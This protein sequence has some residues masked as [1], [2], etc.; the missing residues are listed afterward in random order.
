MRYFFAFLL[1]CL[2]IA[3]S[4]SAIG[5]KHRHRGEPMTEVDLMNSVVQ[6]LSNKDTLS[7]FYL[8]PPFDTLWHKVMHNTDHSPEAEKQLN[9]LREHPQGL[10]DFDPFYNHQILAHFVY[11][12]NKGEDSGVHW[13]S[14]VIQRY[15]LQKESL[16]QNLAGY[17]RIAPEQFKGYL[18]IRDLLGRLTFCITIKEI[19]KIDGLY[20]GGQV[21]NILEASS[22]DQ[23][24]AKEIK[25][26]E[27]FAW[28]ATHPI[29][30]TPKRDSTK[31]DS[32][33][34]AEGKK[35][36]DEDKTRKEVVDRKYYEGKFDDEIPVKL[37]VR[38]MK[39]MRTG[40][41]MSYD[42]LYKFGD[43]KD[44]VKLEI[45]RNAEGKWTM[46]DDPPVGS[47]E[48]V[49][50]DKIYTGTWSNNDNGAGYDAVLKQTDIAPTKLEELD[51]ILDRG[52]SGSASEDIIPEKTEEQ[53]RKEREKKMSTDRGND[54][55]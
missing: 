31:N 26:R 21:I 50:K 49:L 30:D 37:Y 42:G 54:D 10:I 45:T 27:Y 12:L 3:G 55:N 33:E 46:D 51:N 11:I 14:I 52:L 35:K 18:F 24:L 8:F 38:Y 13:N 2:V 22:I 17:D 19:Q 20:F 25:E 34:E 23:F 44:F 9:N 28:L 39:D 53:K 16:T 47:L 1:C 48:L 36:E 4:C 29:L 15:E 41:V 40:K 32:L 7:Y 6:C 5:K 43:Q